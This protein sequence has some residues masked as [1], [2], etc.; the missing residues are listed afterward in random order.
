MSL[1]ISDPFHND[2]LHGHVLRG[3]VYSTNFCTPFFEA[4]SLSAAQAL[5]RLEVLVSGVSHARY[6][7]L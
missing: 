7:N 5:L 4:G 1:Y 2:V 6:C 3:T